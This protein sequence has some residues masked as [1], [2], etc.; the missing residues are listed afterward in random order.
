LIADRGH[1]A[2]SVSRRAAG[3]IEQGYG[4]ITVCAPAALREFVD[5]G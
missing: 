2:G 1:A 4:G 5:K 3:L